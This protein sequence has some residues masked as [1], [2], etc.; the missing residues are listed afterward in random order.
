MQQRVNQFSTEATAYK[1]GDDRI[2]VD[3]PGA[4][5]ADEVVERLGKPGHYISVQRV[6]QI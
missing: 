2:T 1:E 6:L 5:D 4:N 3:I